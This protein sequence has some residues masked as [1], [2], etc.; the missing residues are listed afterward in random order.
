MRKAEPETISLDKLRSLT[1]SRGRIAQAARKA[2]QSAEDA[3]RRGCLGSILLDRE[4]RH[5]QVYVT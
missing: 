3:A 1:R 5:I 2:L 4:L